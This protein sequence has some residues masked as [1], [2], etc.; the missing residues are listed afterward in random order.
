MIPNPPV[1]GR[2]ITLKADVDVGKRLSLLIYWL[3]RPSLLQKLILSVSDKICMPDHFFNHN[4]AD[5]VTGGT[6]KLKVSKSGWLSFLLNIE[7]EVDLCDVSP[8]G[9]PIPRGRTSL[10]ITENIP[11]AVPSVS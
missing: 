11:S 7:K 3:C 8:I 5:T 6:V 10:S 4:T 1:T 2:S 9:C